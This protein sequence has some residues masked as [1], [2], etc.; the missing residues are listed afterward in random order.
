MAQL[1]LGMASVLPSA[2][3]LLDDIRTL[4]IDDGAALSSC[5]AAHLLK[6]PVI[7][8]RKLL[9]AVLFESRGEL[10]G[11]CTVS[12][13]R[14]GQ[15]CVFLVPSQEAAGVAASMDATPSAELQ[16]Y[17]VCRSPSVDAEVGFTREHA[18]TAEGI[19]ERQG[20]AEVRHASACAPQL[21]AFASVSCPVFFIAFCCFLD[22]T[23]C[24]VFSQAGT[25]FAQRGRTQCHTA[26]VPVV[27]KELVRNQFVSCTWLLIFFVAEQCRHNQQPCAFDD[28]PETCSK[29][30]LFIHQCDDCKGMLEMR[31]CMSF[32]LFTIL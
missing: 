20:L 16:L 7:L 31:E 2:Q 26:A 21:H 15:C 22:L 3:S 10:S 4:L 13:R 23:M 11:V 18:M 1:Q 29:T 8:A 5:A 6:V 14:Q 27:A 17:G 30:R 25:V 9:Q 28:S 32:S 24:L 19:F 12:G